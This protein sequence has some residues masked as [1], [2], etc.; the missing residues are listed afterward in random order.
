MLLKKLSLSFLL[1]CLCGADAGF[2]AGPDDFRQ[3]KS[4]ALSDTAITFV[5]TSYIP[6]LALSN[7][8]F[9]S[10]LS[11]SSQP[12]PAPRVRLFNCENRRPFPSAAVTLFVTSERYKITRREKPGE[13]PWWIVQDLN[14]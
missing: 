9:G 12:F 6:P 4:G 7:S 14:L 11:A 3:K 1:I 5:H 2:T 8:G 10:K 13:I